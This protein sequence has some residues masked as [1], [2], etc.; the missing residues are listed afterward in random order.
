MLYQLWVTSLPFGRTI[1]HAIAYRR[2]KGEAEGRKKKAGE[3][4]FPLPIMFL[5]APSVILLA[6]ATGDTIGFALSDRKIK[7]GLLFSLHKPCCTIIWLT[8]LAG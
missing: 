7:T 8:P 1:S 2:E 5:A 6:A 4:K 3:V